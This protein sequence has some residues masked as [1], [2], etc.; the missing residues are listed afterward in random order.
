MAESNSEHSTF[1]VSTEQQNSRE[2]F[3][4]QHSGSL[5][6]ADKEKLAWLLDAKPSEE[7]TLSGDY[8]GP[9]KEIITPWSTNATEI[10][11]TVGVSNVLRIERFLQ[12]DNPPVFDPMLEAHYKGLTQYS[13][14]IDQTPEPLTSIEDLASYNQSA[15]LALSQEE[16]EFLEKKSA[17][18]G[19]P[20]TD[21]E[22]YGFAQI[23][24]EHCRHKIFNGSFVVDG[25]EQ[26]ETLFGMIK[27]TSKA[28]PDRL[29]SAY[30]DNV[31]FIK[32][33]ALQQFASPTPEKSGHFEMRKIDSVLSLK[34]E[35]HNFPTTV[36]PFNGASTGSGGEIRDRMAGGIGS[37]PLAGTAV[38]MTAYP[39]LS[40]SRAAAW[41]RFSKERD[42][43]Y[44]TP[45]QI[46]I[47]ASNGA[48]DFGNKFG[49]P[50]ITGSVLTYE[51][52]TPRG[53]Y[54]F[55]RTIMLAGGVGYANAKHAL[56][57]TP[58]AGDLVVL[59]GGDNYRIGMA[60]GS[61][62]SVDTGA[63]DRSLELSAVQ[64]ANPEMQKR[65]YNVVR[66]LS[67]MSENP[68]VM[69]HDHGAGGHINCLSEL[70]EE[71][72][73]VIDI[74][75][76]PLGDQTLSMKEII[77]NESQERM[78]L[79]L[80]PKDRTLIEKI[81]ER[82]RAPL[83]F[84][85][86]VTGDNTIVFKA[87]EGQNPIELP[88]D[89]IF[90]SSPKTVLTDETREHE[91]DELEYS[92]NNGSELRE[93]FDNVLSL[94][95]VA[96]KDWLTN[97]VDRSVSGLVALQQCTG[98]L[99]LPLN[100]AGIMALDFRGSAGVATS[101]GHAPVAG[102]VDEAAGAALSVAEALTN[103]V[104]VP[105]TEGLE[106]VALSANWMWPA[107]QEEE[108]ARLYSAVSSL[109]EFCIKLGVAV[110]TGKDS[111]SM[112]MKYADGQSIRAPGTVIVSAAGACDALNDVVTPDLKTLNGS[113]L[114]HVDFSGQKENPLGAT[115]F[116]Q[117]LG[118][119]GK[120][121][122]QTPDSSTFINAF[123]FIQEL[124]REKKI[125]AGHDVSSG[126]LLGAVAEMSFAGDI[127]VSLSIDG[128]SDSIIKTLFTEKPGVVIQ[129]EPALAD[130]IAQRA[131]DKGLSCKKIADVGGTQFRL[132]AAE[133]GFSTS[134]AELRRVW[135]KPSFLLDRKQTKEELA[136]ERY[137]R[138][139]AHPLKYQFPDDFNGAIA[140]HSLN[141][142]QRPQSGVRAAI[143]REK[144]TNGDREMAFALH[145]A[146]MLTKDITMSDLIQGR[147]TLDDVDV[148]VFPGGFSNS[149]VLG[150]ARGWAGAFKY[151][152][153]ARN[154]LARFSERQDTLMLGVCNGCQLMV[155]LDLL[156]PDQPSGK[157]RMNHNESGK[158]ESCFVGVRVQETNN[159]FL[160]PLVGSELGIWVAHGEGRFSLDNSSDAYSVPL[161]FS[162]ADYP[163]NPNGSDLNAAAIS[164]IDGRRLAIMPHLERSMFSWNWPHRGDKEFEVSPWILA[165]T[166]ARDWV[167]DAKK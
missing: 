153:S 142:E 35:T 60:G 47:K 24:S 50:L 6:A 9:R 160:K 140:A 31:A 166:A 46:L 125:L 3:L 37:I 131:Q 32:G 127:G 116:A 95:A 148:L 18:L 124:L 39:R 36:E 152:D 106:S 79:I 157:I 110:P 146:G 72:G 114:L 87:A 154:A 20:L 115:S 16:I 138:F 2:T 68:I 135:F 130:E 104:F 141:F 23:N 123:A 43:K 34:A 159:V 21:C 38:Y 65:A 107:K 63:L 119:L 120:D 13:L 26:E 105:L 44:Q 69:I 101:I 58:D 91:F 133:L 122:A 165:F 4:V 136:K 12:S 167:L 103:I 80:K 22:V 126:G 48:S 111:L 155:A 70:L 71:G 163:A 90:G 132:H 99:Q 151:N 74:S 62:S 51:G 147:E 77:C 145:T 11:H 8:I 84:V 5:S 139:D 28:S 134:V 100:N 118:Q 88:V 98:P 59:L 149:D 55:D 97:K 94:E 144:G 45:S 113:I 78:G 112:T 57:H 30:K 64:R 29:V 117:S 61:V 15:G 85:G 56:K 92:I 54:A 128:T 108:N 75:K 49:Q 81:A 41:E 52:K 33:P 164:S 137:E 93:A 66:A 129:V 121:C 82:E 17:E 89:L 10:T 102:L 42:W 150:A 83:Y 19:R 86:E 53:F 96:C 156:T 40:G 161:T 76:L 7:E 158:F 14:H 109:S 25:K 143:L 27:K 67:E 1:F 162:S 73:G